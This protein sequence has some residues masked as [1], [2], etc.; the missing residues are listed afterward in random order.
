RLTD[1]R[2]AA[3]LTIQGDERNFPDYQRVT[4]ELHH[5]GIRY[6]ID[7]NKL[8]QIIAA[9]KAVQD[10]LIARGQPLSRG[11][12]AQLIWYID[13]NNAGSGSP[14]KTLKKHKQV[15]EGQELVAKLPATDGKPEIKVTGETRVV[16]GDDI[17]LPRGK[18]T[19]VSEDGLTLYSQIDGYIVS[20]NNL[21]AVD[22]V[23]RVHGN[24]DLNTGN[25]K[26]NG[27]VIIDGDVRS[28]YRVYATDS[29]Y[30]DGTVEAANI[31][32]QNGDVVIR[33]GVLGR[34]RA[35]ILAGGQINAG[36]I[37][38]ATVGA[39]K[40]VIID[41]YILNS[42]ISS[43]GRVI[44]KKNEGLIRGGKIHADEGVEAIELGSDQ[45]KDTEVIV[46][47]N[48]YY[49]MDS[50]KW[51]IKKAEETL[52]NHVNTIKRRVE[53]LRLLEQRLKRLSP[54]K[55][56]ELNEAS[57]E[58]NSKM[59]QLEALRMQ[60]QLIDNERNRE[61]TSKTVIIRGVLH[62]GVKIGIGNKEVL[63]DKNMFNVRYIRR[64]DQIFAEEIEKKQDS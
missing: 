41:R 48:D 16:P 57:D 35:N 7:E 40:D 4:N 32:S 14:F 28:G 47:S 51:E 23:Y 59:S 12:D 26:Y 62:K 3:F 55:Q 43:G 63:V 31:Y 2:L 6:G 15:T 42:G 25:I 54:E 11:E 53:F 17:P 64:G 10:I 46:S 34:G 24:I 49:E 61:E 20:E 39:K 44:L 52:M 18:N 37:Q 27:T 5:A 19:M 58:L 38:D 1:D 56:N 29:I 22:N 13:L 33:H 45:S 21:L 50:R 30:I 36:F 60:E 8:R 9:K